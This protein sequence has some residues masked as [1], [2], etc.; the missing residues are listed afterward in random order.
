MEKRLLQLPKLLIQQVPAR[1][2][3][4]F[5][6]NRLAAFNHFFRSSAMVSTLLAAH[7]PSAISYLLSP[8]CSLRNGCKLL[9]RSFQVIRN[10][11]GDDV[12]RRRIG[13]LMVPS[14]KGRGG[15]KG[16]VA[17]GAFLVIRKFCRTGEI[18]QSYFPLLKSVSNRRG[19][20]GPGPW[21]VPLLLSVCSG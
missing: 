11:A 15:R 20:R 2:M 8:N 7:L 16:F 14:C 10:L 12:G 18:I 3:S 17:P 19:C 21:L 1:Y 5:A 9:Q 4:Y 13:G 6:I